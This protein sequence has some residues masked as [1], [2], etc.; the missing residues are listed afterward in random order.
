[1]D[2]N[3]RGLNTAAYKDLGIRFLSHQQEA[4]YDIGSG[5]TIRTLEYLHPLRLLEWEVCIL[6]IRIND[7]VVS[8]GYV[9]A[10]QPV[11]ELNGWV[12]VNALDYFVYPLTRSHD[13][14]AFLITHDGRP[15]R[16]LDG[17]T[18]NDAHHERVTHFFGLPNGVEVATVHQIEAAVDV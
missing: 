8:M 7:E 16:Y 10:V 9:G 14:Y 2:C 18:P 17:L 11:Y 6:A 3:L 5:Y 4:S 15:L 1:M 13:C 12:V